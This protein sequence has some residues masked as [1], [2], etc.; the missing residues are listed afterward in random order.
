MKQDNYKIKNRNKDE[1]EQ[2]NDKCNSEFKKKENSHVISCKGDCEWSNEERAELE[3]F[4]QRKTNHL[5]ILRKYPLMDIKCM[6]R[7][8]SFSFAT[9]FSKWE[10]LDDEL[11]RIAYQQGGTGITKRFSEEHL[12]VSKLKLLGRES[13]VIRKRALDLGLIE[14]RVSAEQTGKI[15]SKYEIKILKEKYPKY[16]CDIEELLSLGRSY[17]AIQNKA[18]SMG[19]NHETTV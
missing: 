15:W 9:C 4:L 17:S 3:C 8:L 7:K 12:A 18:L 11:V 6:A 13:Y 2:N 14:E 10:S 1:T 16:G 19:L 5:E